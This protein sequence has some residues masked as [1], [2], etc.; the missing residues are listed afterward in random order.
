MCIKLL[1]VALLKVY[2]MVVHLEHNA[3]HT[4]SLISISQSLL[5]SMVVPV[6]ITVTCQYLVAPHTG[7][8]VQPVAA[9]WTLF[10]F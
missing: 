1:A 5:F 6:T 9:C 4:M 8:S 10:A 7:R 2:S 3:P